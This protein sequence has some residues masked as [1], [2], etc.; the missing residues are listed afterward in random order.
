MTI[1]RPRAPIDVSIDLPRSKS[2]SNR[3][4]ILADL[5]GDLNCVRDLSDAEDTRILRDVLSDRQRVMHCGMGG[6]T[7]RFLLAWA[8]V[9]QGEEHVVTGTR[10][11][12]ER[13]HRGLVEALRSLGADVERA[14]EGF[15][16]RGGKLKGGEVVLDSP[17][18]SQFIS[19]LMMIAP[20]MEEGLRIVWKGRRLSEPYVRMT[21]KVMGHFGVIVHEREDAIVIPSGSYHVDT[22]TVPPDWSAAAFWY[23]IA[24]LAG[25]A[26]I[27]LPGLF[28]NGWQGDQAIDALTKRC[29]ASEQTK[30]GMVLRSL[31]VVHAGEEE[32]DLVDTPDL[33]QPLACLLAGIDQSAHFTGLDNLMTK[34]SDRI[35]AVALALRDLG[36]RTAPHDDRYGHW[37]IEP[38]RG[39]HPPPFDPLGDHRMAMALAPLALVCDRITILDP[40]VVDKSYPSYWTDL[41][42]AG[43]G[44]ERT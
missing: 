42:K 32:M 14:P 44:V 20:V 8:S 38:M 41:E 21:A 36:M 3:A 40:D 19:A 27:D 23:E 5:A 12:L 25:G 4:L 29:V 24:G 22:L 31:P 39:S 16:V 33:F 35:E 28:P 37:P 30:E 15:R 9:Q 2:I 1:T 17:I 11:L 43:F 26:R 13:P 7:L 34:E 10:H 6:T 18:S